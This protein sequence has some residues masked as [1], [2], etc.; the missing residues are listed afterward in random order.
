MDKLLKLFAFACFIVMIVY[1]AI[2]DNNS[3]IYYHTL[4]APSAIF[5]FGGTI[6]LILATNHYSDIMAL[7]SRA[8]FSGAIDRKYET[9]QFRKDIVEITDSYYQSGIAGLMEEKKF[10]S[11]TINEIF[12]QLEAK[13]PISDIAMNLN[14][15]VSKRMFEI[16]RSKSIL[17]VGKMEAP[18]L[19]MFGTILGL[20]RLLDDLSDLSSLGPNMALALITTLYGVF[21]SFILGMIVNIL[22]ER[23]KN[24]QRNYGVIISWLKVIEKKKPSLYLDKEKVYD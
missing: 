6:L 17:L 24:I 14:R 4:H 16:E 11:K 8:L 18:A 13:I 20:V 5:V 1:V 19:G 21:V 15:S 12:E 22:D 23:K 2:S 10:K 7:F 3:V 9:N